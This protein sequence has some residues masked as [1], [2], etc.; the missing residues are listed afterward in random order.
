M[1]L[2]PAFTGKGGQNER[3]VRLVSRQIVYMNA[4]DVTVVNYELCIWGS[5]E[6]TPPEMAG[7]GE[8]TIRSGLMEPSAGPVVPRLPH[9]LNPVRQ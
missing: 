6:R 7:I 5:M 2:N 3:M 9:P 8:Y 1:A 4:M